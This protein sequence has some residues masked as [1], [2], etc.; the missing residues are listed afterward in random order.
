MAYGSRRQDRDNRSMKQALFLTGLIAGLI[1]CPYAQA[2]HLHPEADYQQA[3]CSYHKGITEVELDDFTRC[4]CLTKHNAIEFDFSNKWAESIGQSLHYS[5]KLH[6]KAGIVLI[7]E[8]PDTDKYY[9]QRVL[10]LAKKYK[11]DV[12]TMQ[13][14]EDF[15]NK[16]Y[17]GRGLRVIK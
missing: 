17:T 15:N 16:V 12:W 9:L 11:I 2:K 10:R 3:W 6:K 13:N 4:D 8:N 14:L 1:L 7:M 5:N